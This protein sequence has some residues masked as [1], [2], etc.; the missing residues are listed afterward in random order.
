MSTPLTTAQRWT[1][2]A[3]AGFAWLTVGLSFTLTTIGYY[4]YPM[5]LSAPTLFGNVPGGNDEVWERWFDWISYFTVLS[6]IL[7]AV[8]VT[9]LVT[10]RSWFDGD[11]EKARWLRA[12]RL[13]TVMMI[14]VTGIVYNLL[15]VE[16]SKKGWDFISNSFQHNLNPVLTVIVFLAFGPRGLIDRAA[17][18]RAFAVPVAW[19][20]IVLIR[21]A[22]IHAYPYGFLDVATYGYA[23]VLLFLLQVLVFAAFLIGLMA[24]W[25][26]VL[27]RFKH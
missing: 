16:G 27:A 26:R 5:T 8:I 9:L 20:V 3:N 15:L 13:D 19:L 14:V 6:N 11:S 22:A 2:S 4:I 7:V 21:G 1:L 12:L 24:L 25:E 18:L 23:S 17:I 10:R